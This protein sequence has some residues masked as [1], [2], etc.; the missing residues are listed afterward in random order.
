MSTIIEKSALQFLKQL[1]AN[2]NKPW[3]EA[4]KGAYEAARNNFIDFNAAVLSKLVTFA[5]EFSGVDP[6]KSVFRIYRDVRF[7]KDKRP[8]KENFGANIGIGKGGTAAGYYVQVMPG[9][10][11]FAAAG[12]YM[13]EP[14]AL[15]VMRQE[16]DYNL[17]AFESILKQASFKK[18]FGQ[19][20]EIEVLRN[21]PKG[22]DP[23]NPAV[24]Y[25]KHKSFVVTRNFTDK[26]VLANDFAKTV[27]N[28]FK[29]AHPFV[30]FLNR[31]G[32]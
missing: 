3:F 2:N 30:T 15:A 29:V 25:L 13:P 4:N 20:D 14:A 8:Y 19:L 11:S 24:P 7:S 26:E 32:D 16:I 1:S 18:I 5:P 10:K 9:N 28:T 23:E 21:A 22:Y 12:A 27:V 6:K 31:A 17:K